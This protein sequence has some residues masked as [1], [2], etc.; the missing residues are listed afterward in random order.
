MQESQCYSGTTS[1]VSYS[2]TANIRKKAYS[3]S[4]SDTYCIT[5]QESA[6][7][8]TG[9]QEKETRDIQ[10]KETTGSSSA[11]CAAAKVFN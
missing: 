7:W 3:Y 4:R 5:V 2:T 6:S 1:S 9:S 11:T 10:R 8:A